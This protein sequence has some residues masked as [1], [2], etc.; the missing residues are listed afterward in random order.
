VAANLL[1][2]AL[3]HT[4]AGAPIEVSVEGHG[5]HVTLT[6][7]DHGSGLPAGD[8][9][10]LFERFWRAESGRTRGR[11]GAGLGLVIVNEVVIAH[12]EHVEAAN[13]DDG[14]A[15]FTVRLRGL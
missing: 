9:D 1:R 14:G 5:D 4:P 11:G 6:V 13:A 10:Q 3:V 2:N 8:P 12:G 7:R 15:R